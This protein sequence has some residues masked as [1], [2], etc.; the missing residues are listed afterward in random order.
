MNCI[1]LVGGGDLKFWVGGFGASLFFLGL[2]PDLV[3]CVY[4]RG[5]L[6]FG[7][8]FRSW[9]STFLLEDVLEGGVGGMK[10][11]GF[12]FK[13]EIQPSEISFLSM[14]KLGKPPS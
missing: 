3:A 8:V 7:G 14:S 4:C 2:S 1:S 10:G 6:S 13:P 11:G 5:W 9:P 12:S